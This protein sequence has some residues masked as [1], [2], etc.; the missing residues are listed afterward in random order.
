MTKA[1]DMFYRFQDSLYSHTAFSK[2][3]SRKLR[4]TNMLERINLELK[5]RTR[6]IGALSNDRPLLRL[7]VSIPIDIDEEVADRKKV[8]E[9]GGYA[10]KLQR[11]RN[12]GIY[13]RS[14]TLSFFRPAMSFF[15]YPAVQTETVFSLTQCMAATS[16]TLELPAL[17]AIAEALLYSYFAWHSFMNERNSFTLSGDKV[18]PDSGGIPSL[19]TP[20]R[21]PFT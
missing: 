21:L 11:V 5:R 2:C 1:V 12:P 13:R 20:D 17:M 18:I 15:M 14:C 7:A 16:L 8:P 3:H 10:V 4:T 6:R 9:D 19:Q